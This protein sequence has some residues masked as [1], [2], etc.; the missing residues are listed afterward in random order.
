MAGLLFP[1][2]PEPAALGN[3]RFTLSGL[4]GS[5]GDRTAQPPYLIIDRNSL[6]FNRSSNHWLDTGAFEELIATGSQL[7]ISMPSLQQGSSLYRGDF[8]EGFSLPGCSSMEEWILVQREHFRQMQLKALYN[9]SIENERQG[10]YDQTLTYAYQILEL[11]PWA[12]GAMRQVMRILAWTDRRGEAVAQFRRFQGL[13][14]NEL[15]VEPDEE[16]AELYTQ[17]QSNQP[18]KAPDLQGVPAI[19]TYQ[20]GFLQIRD[21]DEVSSNGFV[22]RQP[23]LDRLEGYLRKALNGRGQLAFVIGS[24]GSGK[25]ALVQSFTRQAIEEHPEL[26]AV[27]GSCNAYTGMDEPYQP[28]QQMMSMLTG[29]VE[30]RWSVGSIPRKQALHLWKAAPVAVQALVEH[31]PDLLDVLVSGNKL[32]ERV[33]TFLPERTTWQNRLAEVI[34]RRM[35]SPH[36]PRFGQN[37]IFSQCS[38]ML[39]ALAVQHPLLLVLEDLHWSDPSSVGILLHLAHLIQASPIFMIATYRP[40]LVA[41]QESGERSYLKAALDDIKRT[42]GD[43]YIDLDQVHEPDARQFIDAFLDQQPN[44]LDAGFRHTMYQWTEGHPLFMQALLQEMKDRA[45][46]VQDEEGF[47]IE[48]SKL[49]WGSLPAEVEGAIETRLGWLDPQSREAL[50]IASVQGEVFAAEVVAQVLGLEAQS[51]VRRMSASLERRHRL[52]REQDIVQINQRNLSMYRFWHYLIQRYLYQRLGRAERVY[53]HQAVG[54]ILE[55]AYA[56]HTDKIALALANHFEIAGV[57]SKAVSYYEIGA[58]N[59]AQAYAPQEAIALYERA[60]RLLQTQPETN[61]RTELELE[62]QFALGTQRVSVESFGSEKV[63][64]AYERAVALSKQVGDAPQVFM[65][66]QGTVAYFGVRGKLQVALD[67]SVQNLER[68]KKSEDNSQILCAHWA[69]GAQLLLLGKFQSA[70]DHFSTAL[71][72]FRSGDFSS[73]IDIYGMAGGTFLTTWSAYANWMLGFPDLADQLIRQ[74]LHDAAEVGHP[75]SQVF[76]LCVAGGFFN[77]L[78]RNYKQAAQSIERLILLMVNNPYQGAEIN[79]LSGW[80]DVRKGAYK[81]GLAQMVKSLDAL[82]ACGLNI[83]IIQSCVVAGDVCL[84]AGQVDQGLVFVH[85]AEQQMEKTEDRWYESELYRLKGDLRAMQN[86][87]DEAEGC[88]RQAIQ[89]AQEQDAKMCELRAAVRMSRLQQPKKRRMEATRQLQEIYGCFKEGFDSPDLL[90][91][92]SLI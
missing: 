49:E 73:L 52:V 47:W 16:T 66:V 36:N 80:L 42:F 13:L 56:S 82:Q 5:I 67:L 79:F 14:E 9:L 57:L 90:E 86:Q 39:G 81:E 64:Q 31:G 3:L 58:R 32:V 37:Q 71:Q 21:A 20:P 27:Q 18:L 74:A 38:A 55:E 40:E 17:I 89:I 41:S 84:A 72:I 60:L 88:F 87:I 33:Q 26:L 46:L 48:A 30:S 91:A 51:L 23:E 63:L 11:E 22:G 6:Q 44:R 25:S 76:G 1:E 35:A 15:G 68:A 43:V 2:M 45:D 28:F 4:R 34:A 29:E 10:K 59:A 92:R 83:H 69:I 62:L 53:F 19:Y 85:Q 65:T 75:P 8:M 70:L 78:R 12:E 7:S 50:S 54:T 61:E 77:C 24:P